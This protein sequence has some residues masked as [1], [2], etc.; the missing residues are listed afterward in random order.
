M[1]AD[2]L[3]SMIMI[4]QTRSRVTAAE[5]AEELEISERTVYRDII[6][7]SSA[8]IPVYTE[9]GPG[10]G[11]RL[12]ENYRTS[13][14]GLSIEEAQALFMLSVPQSVESIGAGKGLQSALLKL[15]ASLPSS[16]KNAEYDVRQRV[17][18]DS[19]YVYGP[20]AEPS[21]KLIDLYK[22]VWEDKLVRITMRYAFG[23]EF[24]NDFAPYSLVASGGKWFVIGKSNENYS[25]IMVDRI[26]HLEILDSGFVRDI[27][28]DLRSY[29]Q[30]WKEHVQEELYPFAATFLISEELVRSLGAFDEMKIISEGEPGEEKAGWVKIEAAFGY[31]FTARAWALR[32]GGAV[33]VLAPQALRMSVID[34]ASQTLAVYD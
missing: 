19:D 14:T 26:L 34:F 27:S 22:A 18:I 29:W 32:F 5:L 9:K 20:R 24:T 25:R 2:R 30:D 4:L 16:L 13:L 6:A 31:L 3:I 12:V 33:E 28:F 15:A 7:L 1:R 21:T 8:G 17:L 23:Y 10:G 11:I